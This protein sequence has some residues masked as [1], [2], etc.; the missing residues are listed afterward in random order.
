MR[1]KT[2]THS[3]P[4][5]VTHVASPSYKVKKMYQNCCILCKICKFPKTGILNVITC[6]TL[7][8]IKSVLLSGS[9]QL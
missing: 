6:F 8:T 7:F 3:I 1:I 2:K 5:T 4:N 9:K